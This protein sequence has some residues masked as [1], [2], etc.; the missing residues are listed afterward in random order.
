MAWVKSLGQV[1]KEFP[2]MNTD[3]VIELVNEPG[4]VRAV[5]LSS[6]YLNAH[7]LGD[8]AGFSLTTALFGYK[9]IEIYEA[10]SGTDRYP[11]GRIAKVS[12]TFE[13]LDRLIEEY[14]KHKAGIEEV[15]A[16]RK[17]SQ[18]AAPAPSGDDFD[19]FLDSDDLP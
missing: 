11:P 13:E 12:L 8:D 5:H 9:R 19:P 10:T 6:P 16:A 18:G 2:Q 14:G 3:K 7:Q 1:E 4:E 15:E 17:A